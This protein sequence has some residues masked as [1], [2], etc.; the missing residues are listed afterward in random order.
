MPRTRTEVLRRSMIIVIEGLPTEVDIVETDYVGCRGCLCASD[1]VCGTGECL[2][3][4]VE[5]E[6]EVDE[7]YAPCCHYN[8]VVFPNAYNLIFVRSTEKRPKK[9][10]RKW[11]KFL[12]D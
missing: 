4:E 12:P 3:D 6:G 9:G 1:S 8:D 7:W 10:G 5:V 2:A 11:P